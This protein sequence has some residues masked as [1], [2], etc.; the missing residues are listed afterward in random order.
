MLVPGVLWIEKTYMP[1]MWLHM[2]I[3]LPL[4]ALICTLLLRPIKG[5][6]LGWMMRL[7]FTGEEH[8]VPNPGGRPDA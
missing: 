8:G 5:A 1:P 6:V 2:V 3:W 4:F 7:G